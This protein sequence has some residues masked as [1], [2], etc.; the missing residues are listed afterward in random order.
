[1]KRLAGMDASFVYMETPSAHMHVVGTMV[2]DP[3]TAPGG[4]SFAKVRHLLE[5]RL[6]LLAPFRRRLVPVPFNIDHPVWVEDPNFDLDN[7]VHRIAVAS[8]GSLHELAEVVGDIAGRPLDH[9]RPLWEL[10]AV[11]GLAD[12]HVAIV[13][14]MHHAAMDGV[15]GADLMV[16]LFD[17]EPDAADPEPPA[18]PW[19]SEPLPS[20]AELVGDA[21][22]DRIENPLRTWRLVG[23]TGRSMVAA[24]R[25]ALPVGGDDGERARMALP[26]SGPRAPFSG[27]ITPH[28]VVAFGQARLDDLRQVKTVFSTTVNDVVLAACTATLRNWLDAHGGVPEGPL[29]ASIPVSVH[30][31]DSDTTNQVSAMLVRLP[32]HLEDPIEQLLTIRA[33]TRQAKIMQRAIGA[34][35]LQDLAQF[36]PGTLFNRASRLYS[37]LKLADRHPPVHNLVVSNIPGPPV[38]L[39]S[40]GARVV[41]VYPFGPLLEGAGLNI[42]VL[43][44]MGSVDFGVIAC[45]ETVP[46]VWDIADGFGVAVTALKTAADKAS[47]P[48]ESKRRAT[49]KTSPRTRKG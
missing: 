35:T 17:L 4:Y 3:T 25:A 1:M 28:R 22:R 27:A 29:V 45:R 2:L 32:V 37:S 49:S 36:M 39:Y 16:H 42:T 47:A 18:E 23:R 33:D 13:S 21:L 38:P 9:Q 31:A 14:K 41:G 10:W 43:S 26:F 8:P 34:N 19:H 11:E 44:N 15:S 20:T 5:S 24:A 7:H 12:G 30:E 48:Q 46:D 6:H 40:A